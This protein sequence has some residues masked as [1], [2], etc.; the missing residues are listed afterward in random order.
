MGHP[1]DTVHFLQCWLTP[2][3]EGLRPQY[4]TRHFTDDDKR[5]RLALILSPEGADGSIPVN[6]DVRVYASLL[7]E[8]ETVTLP[9]AR[10]RQAY[11]HVVMDATGFDTE[12]RESSVEVNEG[13][14]TLLDGDGCF[15][16]L[17]DKAKGGQ[18]TL[19]G[20]SKGSKPAELIVFDIAV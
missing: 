14:E 11:V 8:G 9:L 19:T 15:V 16:E 6:A 10:G 2:H 12:K 1:T 13:D 3:T 7:S 5:G 18:L 20:H 17:A 4:H